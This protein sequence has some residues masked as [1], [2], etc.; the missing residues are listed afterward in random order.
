MIKL[1][2]TFEQNVCRKNI[3]GL[4]YLQLILT[5]LFYVSIVNSYFYFAMTAKYYK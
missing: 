1:K 3:L 2:Y 5:Y 4:V